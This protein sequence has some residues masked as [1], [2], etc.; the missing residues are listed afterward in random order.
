MY[1]LLISSHIINLKRLVGLEMSAKGRYECFGQYVEDHPD[2]ENCED[3]IICRDHKYKTTK[4]QV[5]CDSCEWYVVKG[6]KMKCKHFSEK[7]RKKLIEMESFECPEY[8]LDHR[9]QAD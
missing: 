9:L 1:D 4:D 8:Q 6:G 3:K 2:C 5:I 7:D